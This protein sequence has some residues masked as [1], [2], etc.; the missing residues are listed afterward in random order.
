[1]KMLCACEESQAVTLEFRKLGHEAYSCDLPLLKEK[2]DIIFAFPLC[3]YLSVS[4]NGWLKDQPKKGTGLVG[5][6]RRIA[7]Q[8]AIKFFIL[9]VNSG[10]PTM[11]ENPIGVMSTEY[12][13]PDLIVHPY[14]FGD[15]FSK[16]TCLWFENLPI[17]E[18]P[19]KKFW[20]DKGEFMAS[21]NGKRGAKWNWGLPP[22]EDRAKIRSKTFHGIAKAIANQYG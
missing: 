5:L 10:H 12:R 7:R 21:K 17:L 2:W 19:D 18:V 1:M 13:K 4:G 9:F 8:D 22:S 6:E 3:T 15:P 14:M 20:A 16:P 11:I